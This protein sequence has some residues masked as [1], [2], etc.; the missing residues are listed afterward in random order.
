VELLTSIGSLLRRGLGDRAR[1]VA[2]L[3][4][5]STSR[6]ISQAH[7]S[8]PDH[9]FIGI[10]H[11]PQHA[12]RLVD[13]G[14][15]AGE[16]DQ[17][18]L[19]NFRE[20]WG[21]KSELRRFKDGR[22]VDSVVWEVTTADERA[23][24]PSMIVRH[25]LKRHFNIGDNAVESWQTPFDSILRLPT[26]ISG[27]Y[28]ASGITTGVR[29]ALTAYDN[30]V[31][32]I[33]KLDDD[34]PLSLLTISSTSESLRYTN[35]FSPVPLPSSLASALPLNARYLAPIEIVLEFEKSSKWPDELKAVQTIKLAFFERLATALMQ[36]VEGLTAK[37]VLGDGVQESPIVDKSFL[38]II[39]PEGWAFNARIW[40]D[41]EVG[42]LDQ[43]ID[44]TANRLPHIVPRNKEHKRTAE[45][46]E[47]IQAKEIYL[48]RFVHG[49]RHHR[50]VATLSHHYTAFSGTVRL[51]KRWLASHWLL[52]GH[53]SVETV[54][55][56]CASFFIDGG[57]P[58]TQDT[59]TEQSARHLVPSSKERGFASVVEFLKD[60]KWEEGLFVPLY[61]IGAPTSVEVP[62]QSNAGHQSVWR[63]SS[64]H[65]KD[66]RAWLH[67]GPDLVA[68]HRIKSLAIA[69]WSCLK[70]VENG[71]L[72][73][74]VCQPHDTQTLS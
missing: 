11:D 61:G 50:A 47:A 55:L 17:A 64:E 13:H 62:T 1:A 44:G 42:L 29:G 38:E 10:I 18:I 2:L 31:K 48:R 6:P 49:P 58:I 54:E 71:H 43:I 5:S 19:K 4:S 39:T 73:V 20:M 53:V 41:R 26:P 65:D 36:S 57:R 9:I 15:A 16:Q 35:V 25:L 8:S 21:D 22:I 56:I 66:G 33:K 60:W 7:P 30:L 14:P 3:H 68:A 37:V 24:V 32:S 69:T 46:Y 70:G 27:E 28:L 12:F 63:V 52:G 23:H 45:Y 51:V 34:L 72:N 40:H 59:D 74:Q 67:C